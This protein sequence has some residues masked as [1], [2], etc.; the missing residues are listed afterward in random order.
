[1][2]NFSEILK[3]DLSWMRWNVG[4]TSSFRAALN[5]TVNFTHEGPS[6]RC[7]A[8]GKLLSLADLVKLFLVKFSIIKL[9]RASTSE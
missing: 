4:G 1:M 3:T 2:L 6:F 8:D 7:K 5:D 9:F